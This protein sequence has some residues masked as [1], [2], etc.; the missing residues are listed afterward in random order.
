M[1]VFKPQ[2]DAN[3]VAQFLGGFQC[4]RVRRCRVETYSGGEPHRQE[5]LCGDM[6]AIAVANAG[7]DT[8]LTGELGKKAKV[9]TPSGSHREVYG[10]VLYQVDA[11]TKRGAMNAVTD[12]GQDR[13]FIIC[14]IPKTVHSHAQTNVVLSE[15]GT[16]STPVCTGQGSAFPGS[17]DGAMHCKGECSDVIV[18][19][20]L[21]GDY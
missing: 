14:D 12:S 18:Q 20:G 3:G 19:G 6:G 21:V 9:N 7:S 13:L 2:P 4:N 11:Y 8:Q 15:N 10:V 17:Q 16:G 1:G 5:F